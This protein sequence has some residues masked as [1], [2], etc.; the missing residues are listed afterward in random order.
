MR[1]LQEIIDE[2]WAENLEV[3]IPV[4]RVLEIAIQ[5]QRN[6]IL[7]ESLFWKFK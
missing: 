6:E 4:E 5:I 1:K 2:L 3:N 7:E